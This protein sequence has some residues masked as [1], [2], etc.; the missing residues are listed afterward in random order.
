MATPL[1]SNPGMDAL[2]DELADTFRKVVV[3]LS[4]LLATYAGILV[5]DRIPT[6]LHQLQAMQYIDYGIHV[7]TRSNTL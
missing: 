5:R 1:S 7:Q 3:V 6:R 4:L 2:Q